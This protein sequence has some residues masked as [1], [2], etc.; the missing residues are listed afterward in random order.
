MS[1]TATIARTLGTAYGY[2]RYTA[3]L[4]DWSE[5][6][7]IVI[8]GIKILIVMTLLAGRATRQA[9]E[10]LIVASERLGKIYA[11]LVVGTTPTTTTTTTTVKEIAIVAETDPIL[12]LRAQGMS[13]RAI[14][15]EL[16]ITRYAVRRRL[17]EI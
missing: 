13:Q 3:S 5:V 6:Q 2:T 16:G 4:I 1:T 7:E 8:E 14:A 10:S 15:A 11:R 9:W 12:A 17:Q